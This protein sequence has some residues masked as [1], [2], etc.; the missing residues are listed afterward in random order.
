MVNVNNQ[1][2]LMENL[3]KISQLPLFYS[4][5][6]LL[7]ALKLESNLF[8]EQDHTVISINLISKN[9]IADHMF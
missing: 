6:T 9:F 8:V 2:S 1:L 3:L 7:N 5:L 4:V